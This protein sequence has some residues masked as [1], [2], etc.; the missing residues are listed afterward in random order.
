MVGD[1]APVNLG[2]GLLLTRNQSVRG[3]ETNPFDVI[4]V[5]SGAGGV[6]KGRR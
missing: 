4:D 3:K 6:L 5:A 1:R 2:L